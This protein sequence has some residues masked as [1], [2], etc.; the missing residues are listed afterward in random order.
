MI[1]GSIS[2]AKATQTDVT[3]QPNYAPYQGRTGRREH[4]NRQN[5]SYTSDEP[6]HDT[7]HILADAQAEA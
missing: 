7:P 2:V 5:D 6:T 4:G 1:C 3:Q